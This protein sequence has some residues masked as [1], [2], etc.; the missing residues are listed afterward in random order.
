MDI[1]IIECIIQEYESNRRID[2]DEDTSKH[3]CHAKLEPV[4]SYTFDD[5]L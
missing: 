3:G 2:I 4:F 1:I 5:I